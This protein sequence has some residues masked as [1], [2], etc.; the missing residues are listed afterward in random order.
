MCYVCATRAYQ[1]A[2]PRRAIRLP[3]LA[4]NAICRGAQTLV[5]VINNRHNDSC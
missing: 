3:M 5:M 1:A 2:G 4:S